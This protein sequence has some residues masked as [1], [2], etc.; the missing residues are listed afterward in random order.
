ML[1]LLV[2]TFPGKLIHSKNDATFFLT[3][4]I[5]CRNFLSKD[6]SEKMCLH[7]VQ[8]VL[9]FF[10][11]KKKSHKRNPILLDT[12]TNILIGRLIFFCIP[13]RV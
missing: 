13:Q 6:D 4:H 9:T 1:C 8:N 12:G 7:N 2:C 11:K 5:F 10:K 3:V